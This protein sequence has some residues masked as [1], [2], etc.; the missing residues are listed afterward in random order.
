MFIVILMTIFQGVNQKLSPPSSTFIPCSLCYLML[1]YYVS[2]LLTQKYFYASFICPQNFHSFSLT[3]T[4]FVLGFLL[5][6]LSSAFTEMP[7]IIA[8][9]LFFSISN[10]NKK[11]SIIIHFDILGGVSPFVKACYTFQK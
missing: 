8:L 4:I 7:L 5:P 10:F 2:L 3:T 11:T 1:Y 6:R 9:N